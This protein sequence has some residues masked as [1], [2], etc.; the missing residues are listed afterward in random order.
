VEADLVLD[1]D[2]AQLIEASRDETA[3]IVAAARDTVRLA[4][5]PVESVDALYFTGGS[6]GL[7]FL[8]GALA[9]AFPGAE[10]V[11]GDRLASVATG[12]GIHAQRVFG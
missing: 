5:V 11:Y 8:S 1:F 9:D 7:A 4:G 10:P 6:T 2:S 12:L 3:R